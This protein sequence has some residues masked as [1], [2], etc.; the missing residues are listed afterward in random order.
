MTKPSI[1]TLSKLVLKETES[2]GEKNFQSPTILN[3]DFDAAFR[4]ALSV[5]PGSPTHQKYYRLVGLYLLQKGFLSGTFTQAW[6]V[7]GFHVS[8]GGIEWLNEGLYSRYKD[9]CN[10][11]IG[12]CLALCGSL[13]VNLLSKPSDVHL[14]SSQIQSVN[15]ALQSNVELKLKTVNDAVS[16]LEKKV[17][18]LATKKK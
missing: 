5:E 7:S 8:P 17:T 4:K 18:T 12:A 2:R 1:S 9:L 3:S 15:A 14:D 13:A 10:V 11:L 16:A 6:S